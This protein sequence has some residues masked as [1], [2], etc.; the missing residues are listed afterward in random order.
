VYALG[1]TLYELLTGRPAVDATE[2]AEVLRK[3]AFEEPASLRKL[4]KAIPAEL[5]TIALKCLAKNPSERYATAGELADDL[6][7]WLADKTITAKP[8][9]L[10][11]RAAKW[12]RR[13]QPLVRAT[14]A[15]V[16]ILAGSLGWIIRDWQAR[17][18]E[19]EGQ[20]VV[21]LAAAE[22]KL[23]DGNPHDPELVSAVRKAE[24]QLA[25]GVLGDGAR[26]RVE[27]LLAD[28]AMLETLELAGL[29]E[30]ES[31]DGHFDAHAA[32]LAYARAFREFGIDVDALGVSEAA[33]LLRARA[34][35]LHLAAALDNWAYV[36]SAEPKADYMRLLAVAREV[37]PDPWRC[38]L[39]EARAGGR[40]EDL[41][42]LLAS[43]PVG[44]LPPATL[45]VLGKL[46][47]DAR[48]SVA[49]VV[50]T[51]LRAGQLR[52]PDDFWI[53]EYLAFILT[54]AEPPQLDEAIGFYR[55]ALALRPQSPGVYVN[56]GNAL[57]SR[58]K[59][60]E[61][62][63][64]FRKAV[65]LKPDHYSAHS[66]LGL[67]LLMQRKPA[68]S[69]A[70]YR[71]S[72]ALKPDNAKAHLNLG[73]VLGQQKKL[74]EAEAAYRK[75]IELKPDYASAYKNLGN[76]LQN[77]EGKS[78]EAE[79][80]YRKASELKSDDA[81]AYC[82]LGDVLQKQGKSAEA[83]AACRKAIELKPDF[84]LAY[85]NLGVVLFAQGK[86]AAAEAAD[87]KAIELKPDDA[88]AYTNLGA[89]LGAQGK[90]A[91]AEAACRKATELQPNYDKAWRG[92]AAAL[93]EQSR[94]R[95]A[96]VAC[97]KCVEL[98]PR[99]ASAQNDL[100]WLLAACPGPKFRDPAEAVRLANQAVELAPK[101]SSFW[102]TL[103]V[104]HYRA[105]DWTPALGA[106]HK[107]MD[108]SEGGDSNDW[109]FVAMA[110]WQLGHHDEARKWYTRAAEWMQ[111][112]KPHDDE[113][114]RFRAEAGEL[115][116]LVAPAPPAK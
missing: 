10:R 5:E 49:R 115:L 94:W 105:G 58:G 31:K 32:D 90:L 2:R 72:I 61:A 60:T 46:L 71:K 88:V 19:A 69:E 51:V 45:A 108:L 107:A 11:Q 104:A 111:K 14:A 1:A 39:R 93:R 30:A 21:A 91:E 106:L 82:G 48:G 110:H 97:R 102:N 9:S 85:T 83:E 76:V 77:Q 24:A 55:A 81:T 78:A 100:A 96:E 12:A 47:H 29:A 74:A 89:D 37:D 41:E 22:P 54:Q 80:A 79:V 75:A 114:R 20:V 66:G 15:V 62:E 40:R 112:H 56:L 16:L 42:K 34:I 44:G 13:H 116:G 63:A 53:N 113:L 18:I 57:N 33:A 28:L 7:R 17:R 84:A 8:P 73:Y 6:R 35:R 4:D 26:H 25:S 65:A 92:L 109:F 64:I 50:V 67:A 95:E 103:G 68:E 3:L 36:R 87:R 59:P 101:N 43:A 27:Q 23:R 99:D 52:Y 38:A 70:A 86:L 98:Q